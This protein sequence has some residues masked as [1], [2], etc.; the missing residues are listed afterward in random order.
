MKTDGPIFWESLAKKGADFKNFSQNVLVLQL[1]YFSG[2]G[3]NRSRSFLSI[4]IH[5]NRHF[6]RKKT[7]IFSRTISKNRYFHIYF[8]HTFS[9]TLY[10][11]MKS[12]Q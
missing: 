4:R 2:F 8:Y 9:I 12:D 7:K 3:E 11:G 6:E 1:I 5:K 10:V